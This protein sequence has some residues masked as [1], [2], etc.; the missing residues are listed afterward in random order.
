MSLVDLKDTWRN[1]RIWFWTPGSNLVLESRK[2]QAKVPMGNGVVYCGN[3]YRRFFVGFSLGQVGIGNK[4]S[5]WGLRGDHA[6][7]SYQLSFVAEIA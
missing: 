7:K 5:L 4:G 3:G 2:P 6:W 1:A